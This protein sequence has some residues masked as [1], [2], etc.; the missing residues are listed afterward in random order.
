MIKPEYN[1]SRILVYRL[2]LSEPCNA[3]RLRVRSRV[4]FPGGVRSPLTPPLRP[5]L[6][7][8]P[9]TPP[10]ALAPLSVVVASS[11]KVGQLLKAGA[12]VTEVVVVLIARAAGVKRADGAG[13]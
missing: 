9:G 1:C 2:G 8:R 13:G 4:M 7:P 5:S 6:Q 10:P 3:A 11:V 12:P